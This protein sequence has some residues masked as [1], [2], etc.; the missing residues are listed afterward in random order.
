MP[1]TRYLIDGVF[2]PEAIKVMV[3]A[4]EAARRT[5]GLIDRD[6]PFVE[7]VA[8]KVIEIAQTGERDPETL[9]D[10]ALLS[11]TTKRSA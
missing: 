1:L 4:F 3:A 5:L 6:D 9:R 2:E 10:L 11:L 7:I 8:R